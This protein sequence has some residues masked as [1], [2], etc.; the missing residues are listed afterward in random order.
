MRTPILTGTLLLLALAGPASAN[1][2]AAPGVTCEAFAQHVHTVLSTTG[3]ADTKATLPG[4]P[5]LV[6]HCKGR[7]YDAGHARCYLAAKDAKTMDD[8]NRKP[9][10]GPVDATPKRRIEALADNKALQPPPLSVDG[11][12]MAY[13]DRCGM[14]YKEIAPAGAIFIA[15]DGKV[16]IGPLVTVDE[17]KNVSAALAAQEQARHEIVMGFIRRMPTGS[18]TVPVHV[19]DS[20]GSYKGIEYR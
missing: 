6:E 17:V 16:Q 2:E 8:C 13:D 5:K 7:P 10:L 11:D 14:L 9:F 18:W 3:T 20:N 1:D 15:C 19:Y 4:L 12:Y